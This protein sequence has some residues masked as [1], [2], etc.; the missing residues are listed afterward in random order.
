ME[1]K[2]IIYLSMLLAITVILSIFESFIPLFNGIIP[3]LKIGLANIIIVYS[4]Y[5]YGFKDTL[6][7][8]L[9][10]V[11]LV[12]I[13]RTGLFSI[14]FFIS[15][16][17]SCFSIIMMYIVKKTKL[18]I[19]GVSI[20]GAIFHSIGQVVMAIILLKSFNLIYYLPYLFIFSIFTGI[21][22]GSISK[23][24]IKKIPKYCN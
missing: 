14:G 4:L 6:F 5:I 22:I 16:S 2:K 18:S 1:I 24:L 9:L 19:I 8:S 13:L 3:G 7:L 12:G 10:K 20:I 23:E 21:I 11:L 17:G 15:L